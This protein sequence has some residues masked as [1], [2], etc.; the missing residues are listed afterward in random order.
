MSNLDLSVIIP[1]L[2]ESENLKKLIPEIKKNIKKKIRFEI[3]AI[4]GTK[5]DY[6]TKQIAKQNKIKYLN[7]SI[8]N[9]YGNAVRLGIK[10][11]M[12]ICL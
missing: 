1:C 2:K 6:K 3:I 12:G 9:D 8:N 4:D 5:V 11:S 10:K 7:R